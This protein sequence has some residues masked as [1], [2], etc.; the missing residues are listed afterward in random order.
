MDQF[1]V[2]F[3][4]GVLTH[5]EQLKFVLDRDFIEVFDSG[6][7]YEVNITQYFVVLVVEYIVQ[8]RLIPGII[9]AQILSKRFVFHFRLLNIKLKLDD[10]LFHN[11]RPLTQRFLIRKVGASQLFWR[12]SACYLFLFGRSV[13]GAASALQE[14]R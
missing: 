14:M 12:L 2:S 3:V 4:S 6:L 13:V 11:F 1:L 10:A 9:C 5:P 7:F 8:V